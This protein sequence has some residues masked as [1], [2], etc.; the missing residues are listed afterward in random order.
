MTDSFII[1]WCDDY[2]YWDAENRLKATEGGGTSTVYDYDYSGICV[3]QK[4][5]GVETR[6]L[7][8]KNRNYAQ[9]LAEY[10]PS[11]T[12]Q[13]AYVFGSDLIAQDRNGTKSFYVY[14][15]LGS[16]R[17]LTDATG[18]VTD[19]YNYDAY[20]NL[21]SSTGT[22]V[23]SY[24]YA[25]EQ[26]DKN[27]GDYYLRD[28]YYSTDIGRFTQRDRF[29]GDMMNP[30]SL[31]RYGYT[32]G[33]PVN[34]TDPSGMFQ[35]LQEIAVVNQMISTLSAI[36]AL[37][38]SQSIVQSPRIINLLS[39]QS[40]YLL[41]ASIPD[42]ND[43]RVRGIP[44]IV[45]GLD[46]GVTTVHTYKAQHGGGFTNSPT[47]S[48]IG[49]SFTYKKPGNP[50]I[51]PSVGSSDYWYNYF[52]PCNRRNGF[53][54][55]TLVCDEFP[56]ASTSEG[57]YNNY[58]SG[59]VSIALVPKAEQS[60]RGSD[61]IGQGGALRQFYK[62]AFNYEPGKKFLVFA[63]VTDHGS[64]YVIPYSPPQVVNITT[65]LYRRNASYSNFLSEYN[66]L[67]IR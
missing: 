8:D 29:D 41:N 11:G 35:T 45:W 36:T 9:V 44:F 28:R 33:N 12:V 31:N 16:T 1:G 50:R 25:G 7:V 42:K 58:R 60:L 3:S 17:A 26:F 54:T 32:H 51:E 59:T 39:L 46:Y 30:L 22:T 2:L 27:L 52:S 18:N 4:V 40:D 55:G 43:R 67:N 53:P 63:N 56:Y 66:R 57:G 23:N 34:G 5:N 10:A 65:S 49:I 15:G 19:T 24:L 38:Y 20:G 14:D 62:D 64:F 37:N 61:L 47:G 13:V 48:S 6:F 21:S